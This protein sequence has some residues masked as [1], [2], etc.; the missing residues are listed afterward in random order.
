MAQ[1]FYKTGYWGERL[2]VNW[3]RQA[4]EKNL[5]DREEVGLLNTISSYIFFLQFILLTNM[6]YKPY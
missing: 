5:S 6:H 3:P 4:E 1:C 2:E